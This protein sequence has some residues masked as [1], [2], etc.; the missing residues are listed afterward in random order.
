MASENAGLTLANVL[1]EKKGSTAYVTVNRPKVLNAL[2]TPTWSDLRK[3]F[4]DA[5]DDA[6]IRGVILTGAGDKA[7]IAGADISELA[8]VTAFEAEQSSRFGQGVLDIIESLGKP[9]VAAV[10]GFA[11]GGGCEAA[12]ACTIR[13]AVESARFGQP[14]VKLGLVPGGGGTQRLPRLVGKGRALHLI[15]SGEMITAQEAYRIGLVNEIVS[16]AELITRAEAILHAIGSN[17]PIAVKLALEAA[18]MGMETSQS[19]GLLLEASYFGLCAATEDKKEGTTA[20]LEKRLPQ[21]RGR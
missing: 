9:V 12:M 2:N 17:A 20:F 4:E 13:I 11:L 21:F 15:L 18:N 8:Q 10:N 19:E 6:A 1:Y 5:R 14:E 16:P 3:A 7:F